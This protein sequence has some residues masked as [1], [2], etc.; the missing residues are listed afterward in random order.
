MTAALGAL[1]LMLRAHWDI[2]PREG[3]AVLVLVD[4]VARAGPAD[5]AGARHTLTVRDKAERWTP[6]FQAVRTAM[7]LPA[8]PPGR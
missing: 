5:P 7:G 2:I 1:G 8:T 3:K 6:A 4:V